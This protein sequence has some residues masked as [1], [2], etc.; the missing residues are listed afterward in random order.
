MDRDESITLEK[1][2]WKI[3]FATRD[4]REVEVFWLTYLM[5]T[6]NMK[7]YFF[8]EIEEEVRKVFRD[9]MEGQ[10]EHHLYNESFSNQ[11]ES[12]L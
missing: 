3:I 5:M 11:L 10:F 9:T 4:F 6:K 1:A 12:D 8:E 2:F 7:D